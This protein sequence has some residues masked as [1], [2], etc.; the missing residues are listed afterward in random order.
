M[1]SAEAKKI[2]SKKEICY[3]TMVDK[4]FKRCPSEMIT[5]MINI[6]NKTDSISLRVLDWYV[7][8]YAKKNMENLE[9]SNGKDCEACFDVHINYK[10][11]LKS[12]KKKYFDPFRRKS[13]FDYKFMIDG[14][15]V[16]LVT[17][18]GQLNFFSWAIKNGIIGFVDKQL[19]PI[20]KAMNTSNKEDKKRK[21]ER[22]LSGGDSESEDEGEGEGADGNSTG[23][24]EEDDGDIDSSDGEE[25]DKENS[26]DGNQK[27]VDEADVKEVDTKKIPKRSVKIVKGK[28]GVNVTANS[29][30]V[31]DEVELTLRF[32]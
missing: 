7:T 28:K 26:K 20:T 23:G 16:V 30:C 6:I 14:K 31:D 1:E 12:Y 10:A 29:S 4:F 32:D 13:K 5:K 11:Q 21:E 9:S 19:T 2:F 8:R 24:G 17:T 25:T 22:K 27:G 3:F 15:E 18:I